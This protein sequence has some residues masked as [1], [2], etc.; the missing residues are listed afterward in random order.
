MC[1]D[2]FQALQ[3]ALYPIQIPHVFTYHVHGSEGLAAQLIDQLP[4][5]RQLGSENTII[6]SNHLKLRETSTPDRLVDMLDLSYMLEIW[7]IYC[8]KT[9]NS[10]K[11]VFQTWAYSIWY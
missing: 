4:V 5:K 10:E 7:E 11:S 9:R 2:T 6:F 3:A 1:K 8:P